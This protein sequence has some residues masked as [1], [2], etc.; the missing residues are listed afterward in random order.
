MNKHYGT[1]FDMPVAYGATPKLAGLDGH[2]IKPTKLQ[3]I[4]VKVVP[5]K[6]K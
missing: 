3:D 6:R 1:K 4:A 2:V 5:G